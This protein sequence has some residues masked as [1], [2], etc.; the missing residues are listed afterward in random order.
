MPR[1]T[2]T[3]LGIALTVVLGHLGVVGWTVASIQ[4]GLWR[5]RPIAERIQN[6]LAPQF[7]GVVPTAVL[8][9]QILTPNSSVNSDTQPCEVTLGTGS[10][11]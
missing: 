4:L 11:A 1:P 7:P 5:N 3:L 2:R 10:R 9:G 8:R 6:S